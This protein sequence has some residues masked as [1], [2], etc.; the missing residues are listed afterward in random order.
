MFA[1]LV[2]QML[3]FAA[4]IGFLDLRAGEVRFDEVVLGKQ[5]GILQAQALFHAARVCIGLDAEGHDA[6]RAQRIP[7]GQA[8]LV[9]HVQFPALLADIGDAEGGDLLAADLDLLDRGE[10]EVLRSRARPDRRRPSSASRGH[11]GPRCRW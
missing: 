10:G 11:S 3:C 8:V 5:V 1:G 9:L 7:D 2:F 6:G 4:E